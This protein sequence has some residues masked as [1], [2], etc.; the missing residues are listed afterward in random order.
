[1]LPFSLSI[2]K[3]PEL[4]LVGSLRNISTWHFYSSIQMMKYWE[5]NIETKLFLTWLK[6]LSHLS[7]YVRKVK[8]APFW[9]FSQMIFPRLAPSQM[10]TWRGRPDSLYSPS[11][12]LSLPPGA[13]PCLTLY[14]ICVITPRDRNGAGIV[15][16]RVMFSRVALLIPLLLDTLLLIDT[17]IL[18]WSLPFLPFTSHQCHTGGGILKRTGCN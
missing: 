7:K 12:P 4:D 14:S 9:Y 17:L 2:I 8:V 3:E 10:Y 1:M 13:G 11:A 18:H 6:S 16:P 5:P 15:W